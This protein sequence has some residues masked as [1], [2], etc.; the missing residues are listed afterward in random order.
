MPCYVCR[1]MY[2][3]S[4]DLSKSGKR[5]QIDAPSVTKNKNEDQRNFMY[6]PRLIHT[7][8]HT[9]THTDALLYAHKNT[10]IK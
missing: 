7:H 8:T 10:H 6:I 3:C 4:G 5:F 2:P 9:H 1:M